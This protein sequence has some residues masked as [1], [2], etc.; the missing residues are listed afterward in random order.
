MTEIEWLVIP[1]AVNYQASSTGEI[2]N[3]K[4][5]ILNPTMTNRGYLVCDLN[6]V[7][8]RVNRVICWTFHGAP[9]TLEHHSAHIDNIKYHNGKDNLYWATPL[10]NSADLKASGNARYAN[11]LE[12]EDVKHIRSLTI[13]G[14]SIS[15]IH[16]HLYDHLSR[17]TISHAALGRTWRQIK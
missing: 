5:R 1:F 16:R 3:S 4:S 2:R 13:Q 12:A 9:P 7:Q 14:Y 8:Y 15:S 17:A 10:E 6:G 11:K